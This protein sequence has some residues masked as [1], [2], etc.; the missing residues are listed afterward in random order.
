MAKVVTINGAL[1]GATTGTNCDSTVAQVSLAVYCASCWYTSV[2]FI[3][4]RLLHCK[5]NHKCVKPLIE[6]M[7]LDVFIGF[8]YKFFCRTTF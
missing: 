5:K 8:I 7:L 2:C 4:L 6:V 3:F 1:T